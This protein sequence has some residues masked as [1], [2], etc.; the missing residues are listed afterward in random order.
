[1]SHSPCSYMLHLKDV[2][3]LVKD[4][5][6]ALSDS[7]KYTKAQQN[8]LVQVRKEA[9]ALLALETSKFKSCEDTS[10][11]LRRCACSGY[12]VQVSTLKKTLQSIGPL[13]FQ[14]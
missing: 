5:K 14:N 8:T 6:F 13:D 7:E 1:M 3:S 10:P 9:S 4:C 12:S 11:C 2:L